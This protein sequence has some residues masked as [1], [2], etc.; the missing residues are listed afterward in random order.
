MNSKKTI[1]YPASS[2]NIGQSGRLLPW[3]P[4]AR[5]VRVCHIAA[6]SAML[7]RRTRFLGLVD[8]FWPY[9]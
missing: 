4:Y 2:L 8:I 1:T 9:A 7:T 5:C 6:I 3:Q